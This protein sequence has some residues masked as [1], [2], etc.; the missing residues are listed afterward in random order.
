MD[1]AMAI[2]TN[3]HAF[4]EFGFAFAVETTVSKHLGK[5][6][7][8]LGWVWVV[9]T[10]GLGTPVVTAHNT[11]APLVVKAELS[12]FP[13]VLTV[14]FGKTFLTVCAKGAPVLTQVEFGNRLG[15]PTFATDLM[16]CQEVLCFCEIS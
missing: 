5:R 2:G 4:V 6:G 14:A 16:G 11:S 9:E 12:S 8:L 15:Q 13:D 3:Q 1:L 7:I 10:Q